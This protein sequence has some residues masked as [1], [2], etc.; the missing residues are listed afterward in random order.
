[1]KGRGG[2]G[3]PENGRVGSDAPHPIMQQHRTK[4]ASGKASPA[5]RGGERL[6]VAQLGR[7]LA[8]NPA[9]QHP[10]HTEGQC[11]EPN[12]QHAVHCGKTIIIVSHPSNSRSDSTAHMAARDYIMF[13]NRNGISC[14]AIGLS[15]RIS[16]AVRSSTSGPTAA[17]HCRTLPRSLDRRPFRSASPILHRS[18]GAG[19]RRAHRR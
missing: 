1:M 4:A 7:T 10:A 14:P 19:R 3:S 16:R 12:K 8:E 17:C 5:T 2:S 9:P 18:S 15:C 13:R 6:P 11:D